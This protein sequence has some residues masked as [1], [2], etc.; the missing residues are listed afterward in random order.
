[1]DLNR[2]I[3]VRAFRPTVPTT[4]IDPTS[5]WTIDFLQLVTPGR[6]LSILHEFRALLALICGD[7]IDLWNVGLLH[8]KEERFTYSELYFAHLVEHPATSHGF[9]TLPILDIGH[10]RGLFRRVISAWLTE[11]PSRRL[12]RGVFF[13]ILQDKGTLRFSHLREL[14]TLIEMQESDAGT[15]PLSKAQSRALRRAL[16]AT[17]DEFATLKAIVDEFAVK[18][19]V[20]AQWHETMKNRINNINYSD[21]RI[22]LKNFISRLPSGFVSV[23]DTFPKDVI[24]LRNTLVHDIRNLKSDDQN[25]LAF[26]VAKLKALYALSDA[27]ALGAKP[28]EI[29][30]SSSFLTGAKYT[31]ANAFTD[32]TSDS[33]DD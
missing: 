32:D 15:V 7:L 20:S 14:V 21:A 30:E 4:T 25:K 29:R 31:P 12:G 9:P 1:M 13:A 22:K 18:E 27:V 2:G 3:R 17:L 19:P 8:K 23:P 33:G 10:D 24:D 26:F 16:K 28:D 5:F 11:P 6:A